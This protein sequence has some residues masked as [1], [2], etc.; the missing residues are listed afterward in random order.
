M[1]T[2]FVLG[3]LAVSAVAHAQN[4]SSGVSEGYIAL[5]RSDVQTQKLDLIR[6]NLTLTDDQA[7]KFWP[8][9][10]SYENDLSKLNDE[11]VNVIRD[12]AKNWDSMTDSTAKDLGKKMLEYQEERVELRKKY[13]DRI[14]KE[15][16]PIVSAKFFQ[17]EVLLEEL[18]DVR[19]SSALP[20][21]K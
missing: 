8:M 4:S 14:S 3:L 9:Q 16:S 18:I 1:K 10:K 2:C 17:I 13:F 19:I 5:L 11:R 6:Q 12:Y 7:Q 21:I 15:I 20:L